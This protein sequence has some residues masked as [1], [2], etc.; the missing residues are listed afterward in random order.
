MHNIISSL[1]TFAIGYIIFACP[2]TPL[3]THQE[4]FDDIASLAG[5][6][7]HHDIVD[8]QLLIHDR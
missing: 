1:H 3:S 8:P 7:D 6:I 5:S 4:R 2:A